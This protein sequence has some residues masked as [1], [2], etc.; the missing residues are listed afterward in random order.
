MR[1]DVLTQAV[2][3]VTLLG[4]RTMHVARKSVFKVYLFTFHGTQS[5]P[6]VAHDLC[7]DGP[8][9]L[10]VRLPQTY[11]RNLSYLDGLVP[12]DLPYLDLPT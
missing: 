2:M 1:E 8:G 9:S 11:D 7:T 4:A 12:R 10:F 3:T 5:S 6:V